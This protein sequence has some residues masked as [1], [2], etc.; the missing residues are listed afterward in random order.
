MHDFKAIFKVMNKHYGIQTIKE[1]RLRNSSSIIMLQ[2]QSLRKHK[3]ENIGMT[4][5]ENLGRNLI[6]HH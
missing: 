4:Y 1:R 6:T 3:I 5:L 2:I